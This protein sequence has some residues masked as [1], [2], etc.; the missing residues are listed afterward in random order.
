[1]YLSRQWSLTQ[2]GEADRIDTICI[3]Y[4]R[5]QWRWLWSVFRWI[6]FHNVKGIT[7]SD[8]RCSKCWLTINIC[9]DRMFYI[10]GLCVCEVA[11]FKEIRKGVLKLIW[12]FAISTGCSYGPERHI[13]TAKLYSV[14]C[15]YSELM[16]YYT[17]FMFYFDSEC[18]ESELVFTEKF[19]VKFLLY[20]LL[21]SVT[22]C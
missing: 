13:A 10:C 11:E 9:N 1:M 20:Y 19:M 18:F 12:W 15:F 14:Q 2:S 7:S 3:P 6:L 22:S 17:I 16:Y 8:Q 5:Q 4:L 21:K